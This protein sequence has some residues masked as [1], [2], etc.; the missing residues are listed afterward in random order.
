MMIALLKFDLFISALLRLIIPHNNFFNLLFSFFSLRGN[1][2]LIWILVIVMAVIMEERKNPGLSDRDKKFIAFFLISFLTAAIMSTFVLK[3]IF[4][5]PRPI[6][7]KQVVPIFL[8]K[9][10]FLN[11]STCPRD[12]SFPSGHATTAFAAATILTAF[13]KKR[14]WL[15]YLTA[16]LISYSR[17]YLGCHYFFDVLVG[18][19]LGYLLSKLILKVNLT[20]WF[21]LLLQKK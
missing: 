1:S 19:F 13:N 16:V 14:K 21:N 18:A 9:T 8:N 7:V 17:I 12:F 3:N 11:N 5:R 4:R 6:Y 10:T 2:I 20:K 15:Y